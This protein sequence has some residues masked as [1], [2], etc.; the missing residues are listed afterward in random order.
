MAML[1]GKK[2]ISYLTYTP[3]NITS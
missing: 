3:F 1:D 2:N